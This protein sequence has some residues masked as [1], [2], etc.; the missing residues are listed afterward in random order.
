MF[1]YSAYGLTFACELQLPEMMQSR[2]P[3]EFADVHISLG[4]VAQPPPEAFFAKRW[5]RARDD[6]VLVYWPEVGAFSIS[7]GNRVVIDPVEGCQPEVLRL[8]LLGTTLAIVLHQRGLAVF[9]AGA[10]AIDGQGVML[11]G[12]KGAG[13]SSLAAAFHSLGHGFLSDDLAVLDMDR[14]PYAMLPGFPYVKLWPDSADQLFSGT[15][16]ERLRAGS[17]KLGNRLPLNCAEP[18]PLKAV[19]LL[20]E[21]PQLALEPLAPQAAVVELMG[22]WY[23]ARFGRE[24][25]ESLGPER[26]LHHCSEVAQSARIFRFFRPNNI[27]SLQNQALYASNALQQFLHEN[28]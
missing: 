4:K 21:G 2:A 1:G 17:E 16:L 22:H 5:I 27:S 28:S 20:D 9:H 24:L 6:Q 10:V 26:H 15:A 13:K 3:D 23:G 14:R 8:F 7:G 18:V 19:L 12:K 25:F 11:V